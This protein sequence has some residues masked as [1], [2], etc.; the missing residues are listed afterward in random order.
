MNSNHLSRRQQSSQQVFGCQIYRSPTANQVVEAYTIPTI[1]WDPHCLQSEQN[2]DVYLQSIDAAQPIHVW[3]NVVASS[4][5]ISSQ[6]IPDW[7]N[8]TQSVSLQLVITPYDVP[9]WA[10]LGPGPIFFAHFNGTVPAGAPTPSNA[11]DGKQWGGPSIEYLTDLYHRSHHALSSGKLGAAIF[12]PLFAVAVAITAYIIISRRRNGQASKRWSEYVDKRMS[13]IGSQTWQAGE[14]PPSLPS[15]RGIPGSRVASMYRHSASLPPRS[16]MAGSSNPRL[17]TFTLDP[18]I[19]ARPPTL[20]SH[21]RNTSFGSNGAARVSFV[22]H[23][24]GLSSARP[25]SEVLHHAPPHKHSRLNSSQSNIHSMYTSHSNANRSASNLRFEVDGSSKANTWRA[26][27]VDH[28]E[29]II[30]PAATQ[31]SLSLSSKSL[32]INTDVTSSPRDLD[33]HTPGMKRLEPGI[34]VLSPDDALRQYTLFRHGA[35]NTSSSH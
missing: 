27:G 7:W 21:N 3:K 17:S 23:P 33:T 2:I 18:S 19:T 30:T 22:D 28:I 4:A 16:S 13:V 9:L 25:N 5:K 12:L 14:E 6:F 15:I 10:G 11:H 8:S 32:R 35:D 31:S 29:P 24:I 1:E 20:L 26:S 34:S